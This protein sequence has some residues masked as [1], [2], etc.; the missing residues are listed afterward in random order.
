[1]KELHIRLSETAQ[2]GTAEN[3]VAEIVPGPN[4]GDCDG[5]ANGATSWQLSPPDPLPNGETL[6]SF[7]ETLLGLEFGG[8]FND[9]AGIGTYL[10]DFLFGPERGRNGLYDHWL[11][12]FEAAQE[13]EV[14]GLRT[15]LHL[16]GDTLVAVPWELLRYGEYL[17]ATSKLHTIVR[18]SW[19]ANDLNRRSVIGPPSAETFEPL[20][21]LLAICHAEDDDRVMGEEEA[22]LVDGALY[23]LLPWQ[24]DLH[25]LVRPSLEELWEWCKAWKPHVF[26]FVGHG[27]FSEE[28]GT[29][30]L[31]M[32][33]DGGSAVEVPPDQ[34]VEVF[35]RRV[36][37]LAVLNACRSGQLGP[38]GSPDAANAARATRGFSQA[39]IERGVQAVIAMQADIGGKAAAGLMDAFYRTLSTGEPLDMALRMARRSGHVTTDWG[40]VWD[41]AL[42][43]LHLAK[44]LKAEDILRLESDDLAPYPL[45]ATS[46]CPEEAGD[47]E[48]EYRRRVERMQLFSKIQVGRDRDR[49]HLEQSLLRADLGAVKP[50]T[51]LLGEPSMGKTNML[52]WLSEACSRR[53]RPFIYADLEDQALDYWDVLRLIRDGRL[54]WKGC[55]V[56][57]ENRLAPDAAFN[58]FNYTL[59]SKLVE[60]YAAANPT[61]PEIDEPVPER[62]E[63]RVRKPTVV[64]TLGS[65]TALENPVETITEAFWT[66]LAR[67]AEPAG[68][69]IFL[70]H[71][72]GMTLPAV[73]ELRRRFL[74]R[75]CDPD[76]HPD[77]LKVRV[78]IATQAGLDPAE[79]PPGHWT[80]LREAPD[81]KGV[82]I[83]R[84]QGFAYRKLGWLARIWARRYFIS[85]EPQPVRDLNVKPNAEQVDEFVARMLGPYE[86]LDRVKP[87]ELIQDLIRP[88]RVDAW[89]KSLR[90]S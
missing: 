31:V 64:G 85:S 27:R 69:L 5:P 52:Y 41:W 11:A 71:V 84:L 34:L 20:G 22:F 61:L 12:C 57:L 1:M 23:R 42:P 13:P 3:V 80:Y 36:P 6:F 63:A 21:V 83:H 66:C 18:M 28:E 68:L 33:Q 75:V 46:G 62:D 90:A 4:A 77:A 49:L 65:A 43:T 73:T 8:S 47:E 24:V 50:V 40:S 81:L 87:G 29:P 70:D 26:H 67:V 15:V 7:Q 25:V 17:T 74:D 79:G 78:V 55:G 38:G 45:Y 54:P 39:L 53:G 88:S 44:G 51:V 72:D 76:R 32:H 48:R 14:G 10:F 37:R 30:Y 60:D 2:N 58:L 59:N 9:M 89:L 19:R 82:S 56:R 86:G 16:D 35:D